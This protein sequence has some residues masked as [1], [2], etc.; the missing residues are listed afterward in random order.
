MHFVS[1]I[2]GGG[3]GHTV[4]LELLKHAIDLIKWLEGC[5]AINIKHVFEE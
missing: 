1:W 5:Q 2:D 4:R 3:N